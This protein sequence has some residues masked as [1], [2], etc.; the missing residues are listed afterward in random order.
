MHVV[1]IQFEY[2]NF[3]DKYQFYVVVHHELND[4]WF[5]VCRIKQFKK[6]IDDFYLN[7]DL[8]LFLKSLVYLEVNKCSRDS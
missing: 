4:K 8:L 5:E 7:S 1:V 6:L 2:S 3:A